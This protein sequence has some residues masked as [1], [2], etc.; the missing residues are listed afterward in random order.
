MI[1]GWDGFGMN[2]PNR[3]FRKRICLRSRQYRRRSAGRLNGAEAM[4]KRCVHKLRNDQAKDQLG[5]T[6][7]SPILLRGRRRMGLGRKTRA[8]TSGAWAD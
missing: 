1:G 5:V 3:A 2:R 6:I 4:A 7:K 8:A